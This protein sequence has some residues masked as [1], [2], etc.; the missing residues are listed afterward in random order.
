[1]RPLREAT[2]AACSRRRRPRS[3]RPT[4]SACACPPTA[5]PRSRAPPAPP[6]PRPSTTPPPRRRRP[7]C[8]PR[9]SARPPARARRGR[10]R[11]R[12]DRRGRGRARACPWPAFWPT[13]P[14]RRRCPRAASRS[15]AQQLGLVDD[16]HAA[17]RSPPRFLPSL[18]RRPPRARKPATRK[19]ALPE[20]L[21]VALP[22]YSWMSS[23]TRSRG[24]VGITP[25]TTKVL[26]ARHSRAPV[27]TCALAAFGG[28]RRSNE[29]PLPNVGRARAARRRR[30]RRPPPAG[31]RR[32]GRR[33]GAAGDAGRGAA[34]DG[35]GA[36][37]R[38]GDAD[39]GAA[40]TGAA[41]QPAW[42]P[43]RTRARARR[44]RF[45]LDRRR[46]G[47][48]RR[49]RRSRRTPS[50]PQASPSEESRASTSS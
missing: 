25:V 30:R 14:R 37:G 22:P 16:A 46:R 5:A 32:L 9:R 33:L 27:G 36:A 7:R 48:R 49:R 35:L 31:R 2:R 29:P 4:A 28:A 26:P 12:G 34:G 43:R 47:G 44:R 21:P 20:T 6:S 1:M 50:F 41:P 15:G 18:T 40:G 17:R 38:A 45:G 23:S 39:L 42:A 19:S 10:G 24:S 11:G 3:C 8:R 13:R